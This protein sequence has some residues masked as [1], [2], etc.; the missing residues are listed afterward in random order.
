M[1]VVAHFKHLEINK[2]IE[3]EAIE[4]AHKLEKFEL[5]PTEIVFHFSAKQHLFE[6][7]IFVRGPQLQLQA[8]SLEKDLLTGLELALDRLE[9]QMAK[10]KA[11]TQNHRNPHRTHTALLGRMSKGLELKSISKA[12]SRKSSRAA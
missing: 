9:K 3:K 1:K 12:R 11:K 5:K 8:S 2:K 4:R 6:C 7:Q 10:W